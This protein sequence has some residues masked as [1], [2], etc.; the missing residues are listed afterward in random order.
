MIDKYAHSY[1]LCPLIEVIFF[2]SL[3]RMNDGRVACTE[4]QDT[5]VHVCTETQDTYVHVCTEHTRP[6]RTCAYARL[7][8]ALELKY[9]RAAK[10]IMG[11][12][13][14]QFS[15]WKILRCKQKTYQPKP[16]KTNQNQTKTNQKCPS[17][18]WRRKHASSPR[19]AVQRGAI[20]G[21]PRLVDGSD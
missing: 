9:F 8:F 3:W 7:H 20:R 2:L 1:T 4:T 10:K 17:E 12:E 11:I 18:T 15:T 19:R 6:V 13:R 5:Y 21:E 14:R 16:T